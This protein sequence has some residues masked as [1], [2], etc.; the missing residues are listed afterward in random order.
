MESQQ[1]HLIIGGNCFIPRYEPTRFRLD[2]IKAN[3]E[4]HQ[5]QDA[6]SP[7]KPR[8]PFTVPYHNLSPS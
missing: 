4:K 7:S 1:P 8:L 6:E 3:E 5:S 2:M